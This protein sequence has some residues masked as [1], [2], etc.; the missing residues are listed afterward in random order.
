MLSNITL[1][2]NLIPAVS[3][4]AR[5]HFLRQVSAVELRSLD[6]RFRVWGPL[7][8]PRNMGKIQGVPTEAQLKEWESLTSRQPVNLQIRARRY[9]WVLLATA[10]AV[11]TWNQHS[12]DLTE[13]LAIEYLWLSERFIEIANRYI[14]NTSPLSQH[15]HLKNRLQSEIMRIEYLVLEMSE[16]VS[17]WLRQHGV[18][19]EAQKRRVRTL[20]I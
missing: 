11:A 12:A 18:S 1:R 2:S 10:E 19:E 16:H 4:D 15:W 6:R 17:S 14:S 9:R 5:F 13:E 3:H 20:E 8:R 7:M